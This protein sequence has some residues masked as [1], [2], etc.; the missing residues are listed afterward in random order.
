MLPADRDALRA[1]SNYVGTVGEETTLDVRVNHIGGPFPS[2][3][4]NGE[5][6]LFLLGDE[7]RNAI[8][9]WG[10]RSFEGPGGLTVTP[11]KGDR[12]QLRA[13]VKSQ[14]AYTPDGGVAEKQT[15]LD[16]ATIIKAL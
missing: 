15:E 8:R 16:K 3:Y 7:N 11:N 1:A 13:T 4:G 2:R 5:R 14:K 10:A 9:V 6:F 12:F